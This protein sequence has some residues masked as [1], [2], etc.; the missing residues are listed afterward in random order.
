[1]PVHGLLQ[2]AR[3]DAESLPFRVRKTN[4]GN[5]CVVRVALTGIAL[6]ATFANEWDAIGW[7]VERKLRVEG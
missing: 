3:L 4:A 7:L 1:M 2:K 6:A 5:W